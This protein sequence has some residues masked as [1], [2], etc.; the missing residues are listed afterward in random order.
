MQKIFLKL[1]AI[2]GFLFILTF[3]ESQILFPV[4]G[5]SGVFQLAVGAREKGYAKALDAGRTAKNG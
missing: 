3:C 1:A 2:S 4:F 5:Q